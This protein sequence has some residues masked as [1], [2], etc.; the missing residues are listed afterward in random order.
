M[1]ILDKFPKQRIALPDAYQQIYH[2]HYLSNREGKYT[3][4]SFSQKLEAWMHKKVA[5]DIRH[6]K[7]NQKTLEIG[8]G[9]LNQL[10]YEQTTGIYEIVEPFT[11][12]FQN[13]PHLSRINKIYRDIAE[14]PEQN[15]YERI[16]S[17]ATFE[18]IMDLPFVVAKAAEHL[19][20]TGKL[21]VAI[22]N[23]GTVMWKLG[24]LITGAEFKRKYGL[25][26]QLLMKFEHVNTADDIEQV[27]K[28]FF[29]HVKCAVY[30][31][32]KSL[33]FY[34]FYECSNVKEKALNSYLNSLRQ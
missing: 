32:S 8:A 19:T 11:E 5:S 12:L 15:K 9:T 7:E 20:D 30:G 33:A 25:D 3:T 26:Y 2:Q 13:S 29:N 34:R 14:V 28:Y 4:T 16:T 1:N 6:A 21:R 17:I 23:E 18:H 22:P 24:T 27:L 31:V 10:A